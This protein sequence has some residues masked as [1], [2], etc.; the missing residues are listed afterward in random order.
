M[1]EQKAV[2]VFSHNQPQFSDRDRSRAKDQREMHGGRRDPD[3]SQPGQPTEQLKKVR[4]SLDQPLFPEAK[5]ENAR[6]PPLETRL[7]PRRPVTDPL[8]TGIHTPP[9]P[10]EAY[11]QQ[12]Q[13]ERRREYNNMLERKRQEEAVSK[14]SKR[15][16]L[17]PSTV[18]EDSLFSRLGSRESERS[19]LR[20]ERRREYNEMMTRKKLSEMQRERESPLPNNA[21]QILSRMESRESDQERLRRERQREYNDFL[22]R[23]KEAE[24]LKS[25]NRKPGKYTGSDDGLFSRLGSRESEREKL[26]EQ[27][28]QEYKEYLKVD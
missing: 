28:H 22:H 12:L 8:T 3:W 17:T 15:H 2:G 20:E 16:L 26:R 19:K 21:G 18:T 25:R 13:E 27:R 4:I 24:A 11:Q 6:S 9:R 10:F 5:F 14:A 23:S 7:M 1:P